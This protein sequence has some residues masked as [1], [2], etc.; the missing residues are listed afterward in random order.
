MCERSTRGSRT[1]GR[2][3][4]G[5]DTANRPAL[6]LGVWLTLKIGTRSYSRPESFIDTWPMDR[7]D[8]QILA[9]SLWI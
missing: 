7:T 3:S 5:Q 2:D 8:A 6:R 1:R 9:R 4:P